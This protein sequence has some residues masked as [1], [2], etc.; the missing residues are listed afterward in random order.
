MQ[1]AAILLNELLVDVEDSTFERDYLYHLAVVHTRL[2][3]YEEAQLFVEKLYQTE[4][5]NGQVKTLRSVIMQRKTNQTISDV[6][7]FSVFSAIAGIAFFVL[8]GVF[9]S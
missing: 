7:A 5:N 4:P 8:R 2:Q 9:K 3:D 1:K 6:A